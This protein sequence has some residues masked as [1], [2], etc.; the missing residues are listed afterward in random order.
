MKFPCFFIWIL[1]VVGLLSTMWT[2]I[3]IYFQQRSPFGYVF[4][5]LGYPVSDYFSPGGLDEILL[6]FTLLFPLCTVIWEIWLVHNTL[7]M[8]TNSVARERN[9]NRWDI[10]SLTGVSTRQ[11]LWA[12]WQAVVSEQWR[13]FL[14]LAVARIGMIGFLA[15][16]FDVNFNFGSFPFFD[17]GAN[18]DITQPQF[19][20][21]FVSAILLVLLSV[22][23]ITMLTLLD[24]LFTTACGLFGTSRMPRSSTMLIYG[25]GARVILVIVVALV[26]GV[27]GYLGIKPDIETFGYYPDPILN[28][29]CLTLFLMGASMLDVGSI[30]AG[31]LIR[32]GY[33][34]RWY[35]E[36]GGVTF[37]SDTLRGNGAAFIYALLFSAVAYILLTCLIMWQAE[38]NMSKP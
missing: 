26:F 22:A 25:I 35:G 21:G 19:T 1:V 8:A 36:Y 6:P 20:R 18:G 3:N 33:T 5:E 38:K 30:A 27:P 15:L 17:Y 34:V 12:K 14:L 11:I 28:T 23:F 31:L 32:F 7:F 24:L 37:F 9:H 10:L 13:K 29:V 4:T 16:N 2:L